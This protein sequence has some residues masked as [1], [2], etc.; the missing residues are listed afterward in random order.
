MRRLGRLA[1]L[2]ERRH[3]DSCFA[4]YDVVLEADGDEM[5]TV[6][7]ESSAEG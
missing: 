3:G 6:T 1:L 5:E 4:V 2:R 7:G